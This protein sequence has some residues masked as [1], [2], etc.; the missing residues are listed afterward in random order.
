M[1]SSFYIVLGLIMVLIGL[2]I[3]FSVLGLK[4]AEVRSGGFILIGPFPILIGGK[5]LKPLL[6]LFLISIIVIFS[7]FIFLEVV[8]Y[9]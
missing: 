5:S 6:L 1:A 8:G 9:A 4:K 2:A 3:I 7:L